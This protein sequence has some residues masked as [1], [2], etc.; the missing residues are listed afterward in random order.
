MP[1]L[2]KHLFQ[3]SRRQH[4]PGRPPAEVVTM[5]LG[6]TCRMM[7][8]VEPPDTK[9]EVREMVFSCGVAGVLL[10]MMVVPVTVAVMAD[11]VVVSLMPW[12]S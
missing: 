7:V 12:F 8:G 6:W 9:G 3:C 4:K 1:E 5:V 11:A 10:T 2:Q